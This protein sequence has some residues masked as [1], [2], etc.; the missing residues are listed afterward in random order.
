MDQ[1]KLM[2]TPVFTPILHLYEFI[3]LK[4]IKGWKQKGCLNVMG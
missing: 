3:D 4:P 2:Y 1:F